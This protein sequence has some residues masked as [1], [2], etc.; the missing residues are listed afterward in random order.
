MSSLID[1][2]PETSEVK[3]KKR[4]RRA[5]L[6]CNDCRRRKLKCDRELPCNR[7]VQGGVAHKCAYGD[8]D[9]GRRR[10]STPPIPLLT[11][12]DRVC[13]IHPNPLIY[14]MLKQDQL[15][16]L[17]TVA[18]GDSD[19]IKASPPETHHQD[20]IDQLHSRIA[21]LEAQ[22]SFTGAKFN[23]PNLNKQVEQDTNGALIGLFKG[24][25]YRTFSYGPTS[26]V[27]L[28][29]NVSTSR[30]SIQS[31]TRRQVVW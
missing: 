27:T 24:R 22:L 12:T 5:V 30:I 19:A 26:P 15:A 11:H 21:S 16:A 18:V 7:C 8:E 25:D 1:I 28:V 29:V 23:H 31:V 13:S 17:A 4:K 3:V 20:R 14:E 6:S 9:E 2:T 10:Q